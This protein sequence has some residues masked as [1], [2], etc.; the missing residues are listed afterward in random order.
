M[1]EYTPYALY[2]NGQFF[3]AGIDGNH[4]RILD[5][6]VGFES[7]EAALLAAD[8]LLAQE[9]SPLALKTSRTLPFKSAAIFGLIGLAFALLTPNPEIGGGKYYVAVICAVFA[10]GGWISGRHSRHEC[11]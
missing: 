10:F 9:K 6:K 5:R 8:A 2:E 4:V 1:R 11:R 7:P 3:P